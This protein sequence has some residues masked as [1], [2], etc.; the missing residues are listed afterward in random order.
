MLDPPRALK[1]SGSKPR[2]R[3]SLFPQR[4]RLR[5]VETYPPKLKLS[6]PKPIRSLYYVSKFVGKPAL[7]KRLPKAVDSLAPA[8]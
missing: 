6:S 4:A 8:R 1:E 3:T 5:Q 7:K 2:H